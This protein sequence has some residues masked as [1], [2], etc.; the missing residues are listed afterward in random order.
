MLKPIAVTF[1]LMQRDSCTIGDSVMICKNLQKE[2]TPEL[3][4]DAKKKLSKRIQKVMTPAHFLSNVVNL[5]HRGKDLTDKE[6]EIGKVFVASKNL[7]FLPLSVKQKLHH[8]KS[9]CSMISL[10]IDTELRKQ[11][12]RFSY[13]NYLIRKHWNQSI[14]WIESLTIY[15]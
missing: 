7:D 15:K 13:S 10:E 1:D 6:I 2:L 9:L 4:Q 8:F 12:N 11:P 14:N 5:K 3:S